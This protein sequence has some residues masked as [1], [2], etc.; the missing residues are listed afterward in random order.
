M[1]HTIFVLLNEFNVDDILKSFIDLYYELI[2]DSLSV[3]NSIESVI[4]F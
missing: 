3:K 1:Y 4:R 2:T